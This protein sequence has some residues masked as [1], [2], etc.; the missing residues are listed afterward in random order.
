MSLRIKTPL[1]SHNQSRHLCQFSVLFA[2]ACGATLAHAQSSRLTLNEALRLSLQRAPLAKAAE[3]S[4]QASRAA[5]AKAD[6][7]PDPMFKAG[8]ENVPVNGPDRFSTTRDFM[9]MRRLGIEQQ[10]VSSDKRA[11]RAERA[12]RAVEM[13]EGN[14][15]ENVA[16]VR[17][18]TA[19]AWLNV[20]YGQRTLMLFKAME[21]AT[22]EDL[23][24]MKAAH[25]GAKSTASDV[26]QAQLALVQAHDATRKAEQ[27]L[28]N[29][30]IV[31]ARWTVVPVEAVAD[32][33]PSLVSH[34][35]NLSVEELE[36]VY[37]MA[38]GA[39]RAIN[40]ADADTAVATRER[41]PD[42]TVEAG[43]SQ[44]GSQYSNMVS[45]GV[46][47]PLPVNRAQRQ[48]RDIAEKSAL[49]TRARLQY[50]EAV[51]EMQTEIHSLSATLASLKDRLGQLNTRLLPP[52][53]SQVDL[54]TAAYRAG[55]GSLSAVFNARRMLLE[56][57]LQVTELEREAALTWSRLEHHVVPHDLVAAGGAAQ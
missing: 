54:A 36:K 29:A 16:K 42:W 51:R 27:D 20:L 3:A 11:A 53:S 44:R 39:R 19:K 25:R 15:L 4:V 13:E 40:L 49:G 55:T 57:Q 21:T 56:K 38:V 31:L 14:Y 30:R 50:E 43:F 1:I 9:T 41:R 2:L 17:E 5:A 34:I 22:G 32:E 7:L 24:A 28:A 35:A 45:I 23:A 6:Q 12:Q 26:V 33:S 46:S 52:A 8:I 47:I 48:D 10:W 37:P 18:E